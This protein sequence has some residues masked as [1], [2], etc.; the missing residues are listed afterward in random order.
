MTA[1]VSSLRLLLVSFA[2]WINRHQQDVIEYHVEENHVLREQL[3]G[4]RLRLTDDRRRRLAA[5]GHRLGRRL[6]RRVATIVTPDTIL[7]CIGA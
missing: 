6:L 7:R 5:K 2:G 3:K 4:Q 1:D